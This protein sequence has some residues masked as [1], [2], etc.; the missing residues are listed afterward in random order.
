MS[1]TLS[2]NSPTTGELQ[3]SHYPVM[4]VGADTSGQL[5]GF[6][7]YLY[8][9]GAQVAQRGNTAAVANSWVYGGA[10]R[11]CVTVQGTTASGTIK[12][13]SGVATSTGYAQG[14][15]ATT[16]GSGLVY[17]QQRIESI[18][19]IGLNSK[20]VV[21]SCIVYQNTG[22]TQ[23]ATITFLKP[24]ST[25]DVFSAQTILTVGSSYPIPSGTPTKISWGYTLGASEASLGLVAQVGI[26]AGTTT[27]KDFWIGDFQFEQGYML[28]PFE[29]RP[30]GIE[31]MLCQRYYQAITYLW[32]MHVVGGNGYNTY[33]NLPV[34]LVR[35]V[36]EAAVP[37]P[38]ILRVPSAGVTFA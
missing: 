4:S 29:V 14:V 17:F 35:R 27:S 38:A 33:Q 12:Q 18:N 26:V 15:L 13:Y 34:K 21:I 10:D 28:S 19:T 9:G 16:T 3:I 31:F 24:T 25:A 20:S 32:I 22:S 1:I 8:N 5:A 30:Y 37:P 23:N 6:R 11:T 36:G 7:N 2:A